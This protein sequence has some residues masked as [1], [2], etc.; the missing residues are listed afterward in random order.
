MRG[1]KD[2]TMILFKTK[3][4]VNWDVSRKCMVVE[5]FQGN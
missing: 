4:I 1:V 3:I 2:K 5:T